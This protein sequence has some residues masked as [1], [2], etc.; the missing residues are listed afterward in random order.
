MKDA[1]F[2]AFIHRERLKLIR[3]VRTFLKETAEMDAEDVVHDVL[4]KLLERP[5]SSEPLVDISSYVYSS[6]RNRVIDFV[7]SRKSMVSLDEDSEKEGPSLIEILAD[8]SPGAFELLQS[9]EGERELFEALSTLSDIERQVVIA[10][11][12]EGV[13]F[14]ELAGTLSI[15]QNTLLSHKAR[16]MKKLKAHFLK[17]K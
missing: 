12:F 17:S 3:Y 4:V 5:A 10:H 15:P 6:T 1:A 9:Q 11:E 14:K 2:R 8:A 16:A 13:S 7:R